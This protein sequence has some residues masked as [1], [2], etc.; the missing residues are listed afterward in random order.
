M[1]A[2]SFLVCICLVTSCASQYEL[3]EKLYDCAKKNLAA[4]DINPDQL[5]LDFE[6]YLLE[7]KFLKNTSPDSYLQLIDSLTQENHYKISIAKELETPLFASF[8]VP[9]INNYCEQNV[10]DSI[11][12]K[13]SRIFEWQNEIG[14]VIQKMMDQGE[15]DQGKLTIDLMQTF[16]KNDFQHPIYK[17]YF[18]NLLTMYISNSKEDRGVLTSLPPWSEE[19][20]DVTKLKGRNVFKVL[21]NEK[22]EIFVRNK[23]MKL[24]DLKMRAKEFISNP[25]QKNDLAESPTKAIISLE[26]HRGT[27]YEVYIDVLNELNAAYNELRNEKAMEL[28]SL[29]YDKLEKEQQKEIRYMYPLIISEAEPTDFGEEK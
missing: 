25:N 14:T 1:K 29:P 10:F 3:E 22:N 9:G 11:E 5:I 27:K 21:V 16:K 17:L 18:Y 2:L 12:I 7:N 24:E 23:S 20:P 15:L 28:H 4:K 6:T 26:N 13:A 8:S 19:E